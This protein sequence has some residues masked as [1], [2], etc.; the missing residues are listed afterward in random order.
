M[1]PF[2]MCLL[3][4][5]AM[6][7]SGLPAQTKKWPIVQPL[8]ESHTLADPSGDADTHLLVFIRDAKGVPV[9]KL[10]C[11]NGNYEDDS[12]ISFSGDFQCAL[13]GVNATTWNLLA[14]NNKDERST[15]WF[16]RGRMLSAQLRGAC[17]G[18]SEYESLRHF[19][20]RGMLI[21]FKFSGLEWGKLDNQNNPEL[22]KFTFDFSVIPDKSA[23]S[24]EAEP[25]KGAKPPKSCY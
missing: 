7:A 4:L 9:Y 13:F 2:K 6:A 20:L 1:K 3:L 16:N 17:T 5:G 11:H 12:E 8:H 24:P 19:K 14:V 10:E 22:T 23:Q 18:Y 15:D 21:T 25:I